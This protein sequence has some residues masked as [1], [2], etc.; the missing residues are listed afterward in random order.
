M[1]SLSLFLCS[2]LFLSQNV[3]AARAA[4]AL[5]KSNKS[6][7]SCKICPPGPQGPA[8]T[9]GPRGYTGGT[10]PQGVTGPIGPTGP[11]GA[12]TGAT[13]AK[14]NTG[15][16]GPTGATGAGT[17]GATGGTGA[18]GVTGPTGATGVGATGV[19]GATG[20]STPFSV[21]SFYI[22]ASPTSGNPNVSV[23]GSTG[24]NFDTPTSP[25]IGASGPNVSYS[26]GLFSVATGVYILDY[27]AS[28]TGTTGA[29]PFQCVIE[30]LPPSTTGALKGS[31]LYLPNNGTM[32]TNSVIIN[33]NGAN[34]RNFSLFNSGPPLVLS[35][36][37]TAA[38][39][40][41]PV[42]AYITIQQLQ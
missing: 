39:S 21:A 11:A 27:G 9:R 29:T 31:Q 36:P 3:Y 15:V 14:G 23:T 19:T 25:V 42:V 24:F 28:I 17:T 18:T 16:T 7:S 8:G 41:T 35:P 33:A 26:N 30:F 1:Y 38:G 10:G 40:D 20:S 5:Q 12:P 6:S 4:Y 32:T 22:L 34:V 13:G 2:L 37:V